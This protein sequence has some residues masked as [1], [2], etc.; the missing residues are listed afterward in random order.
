MNDNGAIAPDGSFPRRRTG[1]KLARG[2]QNDRQFSK[3]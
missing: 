2:T 3:T 1:S